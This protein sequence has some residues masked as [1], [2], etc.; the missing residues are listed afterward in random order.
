MPRARRSEIP[1]VARA[2]A[3][4]SSRRWTSLWSRG[5]AWARSCSAAAAELGE[6]FVALALRAQGLAAL[7]RL[8]QQG[9]VLAIQGSLFGLRQGV[10]RVPAIADVGAGRGDGRLFV[11]GCGLGQLGKEG[12]A[13]RTQG[14]AR[15]LGGDLGGVGLAIGGVG[16]EQP[17]AQRPR[18]APATRRRRGAPSRPTGGPCGRAGPGPGTRYRSGPVVR[19]SRRV[20]R[21]ERGRAGAA[22]RAPESP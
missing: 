11:Q 6:P 13:L 17:G 15:L 22:P 16:V 7:L 4:C 2:V 19:A 3:A 18:T 9:R 1:A 14:D 10:Q 5:L 8:A 12:A 20:R 21:T